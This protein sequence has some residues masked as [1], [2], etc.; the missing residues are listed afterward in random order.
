MIQLVSTTF[1]RIVDTCPSGGFLGLP[2][3][4]KYLK[5]YIPDSP[6]AFDARIGQTCEPIINSFRDILLIAA[7]ILEILLRVATFVA[8]V[9]IVY[10]GIRYVISQGEPD[11]VATAQGTIL[12]AVIGLVIAVVATAVVSF[13]AGRFVGA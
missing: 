8:I 3:W 12:N 1:A 9:F 11:R 5:G 7:A 13:V 10:G 2:T 4:F 6:P